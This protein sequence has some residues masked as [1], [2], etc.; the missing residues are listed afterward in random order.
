[1]TKDLAEKE[2]ATIE[3]KTVL[4]IE[5]LPDLITVEEAASYLRIGRNNMYDQA[6][7]PGFPKILLGRRIGIRIPKKAFLNWVEAQYTNTS[8]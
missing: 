8:K 1:M 4:R 3:N 6:K 5:D 2:L 7:K